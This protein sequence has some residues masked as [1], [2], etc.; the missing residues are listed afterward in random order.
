MG[1]ETTNS[2][3]PTRAIHDAYLNLQQTHR[4]Y[5]RARDNDLDTHGPQ[6]RFQ[7]AVLTFYELV[8]PHLKHE[9]SLSEYWTG[10]VPDYAGWNFENTS[11]AAEYVQEKGTGVYQVQQHT[12]IVQVNQ[13]VLTDGGLEGFEQW[14]DFLGL[15]WDS[16]RL[17][18]VQPSDEGT[19]FVKLLRCAVLP[20]RDLDNWQAHVIKERAR[21]DGFMAG[22]TAIDTRLEF[23][24]PQKLVVAKRLLV[25]AADKLGALSDFDASAQRTEITRED[26]QKVEEWRQ[27]QLDR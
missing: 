10:N 8:R 23:Q 13:Q 21:G 25:E 9:T 3:I 22:E 19:H 26:I 1:E 15:S 2:G 12:D 16:E 7:D 18:A 11:A 20:L 24:H 6:G 4:E 17:V 14:H 5:R 27:T